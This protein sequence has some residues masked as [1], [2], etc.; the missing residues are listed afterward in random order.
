MTVNVAPT[1]LSEL[2]LRYSCIIHV[3]EIE[4][5]LFPESAPT[6]TPSHGTHSLASTPMYVSDWVHQTAYMK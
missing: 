4:T 3:I 1:G 6:H 5:H 2:R